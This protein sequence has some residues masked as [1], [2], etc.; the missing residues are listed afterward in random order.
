MVLTYRAETDLKG[1]LLEAGM[2]ITT[3]GSVVGNDTDQLVA[4]AK[5]YAKAVE[6]MVA[7]IPSATLTANSNPAMH[8]RLFEVES[9]FDILRP[10]TSGFLQIFQTRFIYILSTGTF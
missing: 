5:R 10:H 7:N 3:E 6:S 4:D 2:Q 9:V 8:A 1:D